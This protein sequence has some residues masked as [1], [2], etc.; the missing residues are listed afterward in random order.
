MVRV[1]IRN[2][3]ITGQKN[4]PIFGIFSHR[5]KHNTKT[6]VTDQDCELN[7]FVLQ[8]KECPKAVT[9]PFK[10]FHP[11]T[12]FSKMKIC[13]IFGKS[14]FSGNKYFQN[15]MT[16]F[17]STE[18]SVLSAKFRHFLRNFWGIFGKISSAENQDQVYRSTWSEYFFHLGQDIPVQSCS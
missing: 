1:K 5:C 17:I 12:Q 16:W 15:F 4:Y 14:N 13:E 18:V 2:R 10:K 8:A 3:S 11:N 6:T 7:L 9:H